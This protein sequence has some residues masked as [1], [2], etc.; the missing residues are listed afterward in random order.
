MWDFSHENISKIWLW[1]WLGN[2]EGRCAIFL[3]GLTL[4]SCL[5]PSIDFLYLS[6]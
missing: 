1:E 2:R 3:F 6:F 4:L 5:G